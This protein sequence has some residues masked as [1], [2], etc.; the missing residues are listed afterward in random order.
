MPKLVP[1]GISFLHGVADNRLSD[2]IV[3]VIVSISRRSGETLLP[4]TLAIILVQ[5]GAARENRPPVQRRILLSASSSW[6]GEPHKSYPPG[7]PALS[8]VKITIAPQTRLEWHSHPMPS[9][10]YIV[11]GELTL[12]EGEMARSN[13]LPP[14]KRFPRQS[15]HSIGES[16]EVDLLY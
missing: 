8:I 6:D 14:D 13:A 11:A 1:G 4:V 10:A 16:Q 3:N 2:L 5:T 15:I 7:R 12:R 9:A